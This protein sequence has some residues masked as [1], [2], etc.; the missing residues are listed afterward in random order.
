MPILAGSQSST[1]S[2]RTSDVGEPL[3]GVVADLGGCVD[4]DGRQLG[5]PSEQPLV[6]Q[7][8]LEPGQAALRWVERIALA[9]ATPRTVTVL[10]VAETLGVQISDRMKKR[11]S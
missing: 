6:K 10:P 9:S 11:V 2:Y 1:R 7:E 8:P 3:H 4:H 5:R